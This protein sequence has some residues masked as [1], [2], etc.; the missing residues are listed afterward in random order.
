M[1]RLVLTAVLVLTLSCGYAVAQ[2]WSWPEQM[3]IAGF[4]VSG[5]RG[6]VNPNGSGTAS[7]TVQVPGVSSGIPASLARTS[8]GDISATCS[9][10]A[11]VDGAEVRGS[12]VLKA[13]GFQVTGSVNGSLRTISDAVISVETDGRFQGSG[14]VLLNSLAVPVRFNIS[15]AGYSFRGVVP[16][17]SRFDTALALYEFEGTLSIDGGSGKLVP[18]A[19]GTVTRKGK[20][21]D[22][23]ST[24]S[25]R[26]I[27][28]NLSDGTGTADVGGVVLRFR[29]F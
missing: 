4:A 11:R 13:S 21:S 14:R 12:G 5:I 27:A 3:K 16:V 9:V 1:Y 24:H 7:G 10:N 20:L 6:S 22:Q 28:V 25:V 2:D 23:V 15:S 18:T 26:G 17:G 19:S 8:G 29:F